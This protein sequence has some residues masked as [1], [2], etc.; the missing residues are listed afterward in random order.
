MEFNMERTEI[1]CLD[2]ILQ[3]VSNTELTQQIKLPDGMPDI[4]H[5][6][7]AWGQVILRSK[8]WQ[9]GQI[10]ASGG[11]MVW[12]LYAPENGGKEC[13]IDTWI[14]FQMQWDLP[15]DVPEGSIRIRCLT[16]FVDGRSVSPRKIM[17][18]C[19]AAMQAEVCVPVKREIAAPAISSE[20]V[21][22]LNAT[23]PL[24]LVMEAGERAFVMDEELSLPDSAPLPDKLI[25]SRMLPQ[26]TEKRVLDDKLAFRGN[27]NLHILYSSE[28]GQLHSWDFEMPFSQIAQL[29]QEYGPD[30]QSDL[31]MV[32]T[33]LE[34]EVDDEGHIRLKCA[35][36][37]QYRITDRK[38]V[39]LV[40]DAY[41]PG[42]EMR[43]AREMLEMPVVLENRR[44]NIYGEQTI[45]AEANFVADISYLP[46]FPRLRRSE[47]GVD[48]EMPGSFQ[49]LYYD[50]S[51]QLRSANARWEGRK[52]LNAD[53]DSMLTAA[54]LPL[55]AQA[56]A[57]NGQI[58]AKAELPLEIITTARQKIPMVTD[59]ETG[60]RRADDSNR[61][62]LLLRRAG[63]D[64]LWDIAKAS[65]STM[66]DIRRA[67]GLQGEPAPGQMLLIPVR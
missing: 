27:G 56:V 45:P 51:G 63:A 60:E 35:M 52:H 42:R 43:L 61:P 21:E 59:V 30:A 38:L 2:M 12:V 33:N 40:E 8:E 17:V 57:G 20:D 26:I 16:R 7:S 32:L 13:C 29:D 10:I 62:A 46:D 47:S 4:G 3:E 9:D 53:T 66:E 65:G 64:R 15:D 24:R 34:T 18:R 14:P 55:E 58:L 11:M 1:A 67:N 50:G 49:V 22:L 19:G 48:L 39:S 37:A 54:V 23:Y 28:E 25:Y 36:A 5:I 6:L 41:S 44:E 31:T